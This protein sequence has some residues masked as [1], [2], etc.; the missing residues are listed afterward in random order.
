M[1][2]TTANGETLK[3]EPGNVY[4]LRK[5]SD[6]KLINSWK[7]A[8]VALNYIGLNN[9]KKDYHIKIKGDDKKYSELEFKKY[10][11]ENERS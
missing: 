3:R 6:N 7:Y 10:V 9:Y 8:Q 2:T 5:N 11:E 4:Q 1:K